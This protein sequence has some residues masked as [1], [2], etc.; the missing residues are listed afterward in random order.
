MLQ[1]NSARTLTRTRCARS[2]QNLP[3]EY[4]DLIG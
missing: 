4:L 3:L 2:T 1:G